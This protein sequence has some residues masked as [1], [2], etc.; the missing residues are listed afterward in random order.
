MQQET[1]KITVFC[2]NE[3]AETPHTFEIDGVGEVVFTCECGRFIKYPKETTVEELKAHIVKH[4]EV[5]IGQISQA[6]LDEKGRK[7][8]EE[9]LAE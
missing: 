9:L 4:K 3:Q 1:K 7:F 5:N 2:A 8:L 6:S